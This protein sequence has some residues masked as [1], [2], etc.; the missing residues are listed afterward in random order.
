M[1]RLD[2]TTCATYARDRLPAV[3]ALWHTE[4]AHLPYIPVN[5]P[6]FMAGV[7]TRHLAGLPIGAT[8]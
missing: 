7:H 1:I 4:R 6:A 8:S 2:C 3:L 5:V